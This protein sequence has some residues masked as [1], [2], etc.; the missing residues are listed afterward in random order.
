MRLRNWAYSDRVVRLHLLF[1][2]CLPVP[3]LGYWAHDGHSATQRISTT[4]KV[5]IHLDTKPNS[6][7]MFLT[8]WKISCI[9]QTL[10]WSN[11]LCY[12]YPEYKLAIEVTCSRRLISCPRPS[13][14]V[15]DS[16]HTAFQPA[17][18]EI[19]AVSNAS[20]FLELRRNCLLSI[21]Q[22]SP[23]YRCTKENS[24]T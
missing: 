12:T 17:A 5:S 4:S 6:D 19:T 7:K 14:A 13:M 2:L 20:R 1:P 10:K 18:W 15:G 24:G 9:L 21:L 3:F 16:S 11:R 22:N 23:T 8:N